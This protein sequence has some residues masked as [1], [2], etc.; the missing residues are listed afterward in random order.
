MLNL[1]RHPRRS[2][3][4]KLIVIV[5]MTLLLSMS[6]W[7]YFNINEQ[8]NRVMENIIANADRLTNTIRLGT[9]YAMMLN[10]RDD[11]TQIITNIGK[12]E[13]IENIR[14]YNK[15]GQIKFSNA[16]SEVNT[17]T[18][19]KAEA[20]DICHRTDPP[21]SELTLS[22]RTRIMNSFKGYRL[23]GIITPINNEPSCATDACHVH[24]QGKKILGALDVVVS[25][26]KTDQ[27]IAGFERGILSL[28]VFVFLITSMLISIIVIRFISRPIQKLIAGTRFFARGEYD[29]Q[30]D[31]APNDEMGFLAEAINRMG[32]AI[33]EK[34]AELN[35]QKDEYQRLFELVP[36]LIT[37]QDREFKLIHYNREFAEKFNPKSGDSCFQAYKGLD[38]RCS[39][40]PVEKTIQDGL[41]HYGEESRV[42]AD[43]SV[44]HWVARTSPV[45]NT[46]GEIVAVMEVCL[47]ITRRKELEVSLVNSEKKYHA[48]F[49]NIPNP[50]FV[51]DVNTLEV[52][53]CNQ[54]VSTVYGYSPDELLHQPFL[55]MF[56]EEDIAVL[57]RKLKTE[58]VI[59]RM[60][61][62]NKSGGTLFVDIWISPSDQFYLNWPGRNVLLVTTSDITERLETEQQFIQASKMATLG[63]MATGVAHELNQPL[64]VIKTASSFFIR[65]ITRLEK[66]DEDILINMLGKIDSNVDRASRIIS[67]M[68]LFARKSEGKLE[69]V[70]VNEI[71]EKAYEIFSQQLKVRGIDVLWQIEKNL[72]PVLG[73]PGRLEQVCINL[74]LNARDAIEE[75]WG[76]Q[77]PEEGG[78]RITLKTWKTDNTVGI[79]IQDTGKGIPDT[80]LDKIFEPF[81]TTKE[82]GKGTGLGL[83]ISYGIV[84]ECGGDIHVTSEEGKGA[85][86][87]IHFPIQDK[88]DE[89]DHFTG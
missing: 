89:E 80:I 12:Q 44:T 40:C 70:Q 30:V 49:N 19:I 81:F 61:Q 88:N 36:C 73:D 7:A 1:F 71:L 4:S 26:E 47:D 18:N 69:N 52:L 85:C 15:E 25:L 54:S 28:T 10:S 57:D 84:K 35:K 24:P 62:V 3:I 29:H 56:R 79:E 86:F 45:K 9:H 72:P 83:S 41:S 50:V 67:H 87:V 76:N 11:I 23:L 58:S 46:E 42:N 48:I 38:T 6:T 65:K 20:C 27:D 53:D 31:I 55:Q 13:G 59:H 68:R 17:T 60:K 34:Q 5:G 75:R 32:K 74:I 8:K 63:E 66:I 64:S 22:G 43:G 37:I 77:E 51:L 78:K 14:I 33:G 82:V 2:L 39:S 16:A 21:L